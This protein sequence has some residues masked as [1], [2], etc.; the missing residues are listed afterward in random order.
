MGREYNRDRKDYT[1]EFTNNEDKHQERSQDHSED[2]PQHY[3]P[4]KER[5]TKGRHSRCR[6]ELKRKY[7]DP[8]LNFKELKN[9]FKRRVDNSGILHI[10][11]EHQFYQKKSDK[12][13]RARN[14]AIK[15]Y[16]MEAIEQK[17][18]AGEPIKAPCG[19]VKKVMANMRDK[20]DKLNK[21]ERSNY[22]HKRQNDDY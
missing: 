17:I 1:K 4:R 6:V 18:T 20:K 7:N 19:L 9:E 15:K 13:R 3:T 21:K 2:I 12:D 5:L 8:M 14:A 16:Q 10:L 22:N 11:K